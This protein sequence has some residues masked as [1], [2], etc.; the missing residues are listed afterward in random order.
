MKKYTI[1][2]CGSPVDNYNSRI[3]YY[4]HTEGNSVEEAAQ[5]ENIALSAIWV[6]FNGHCEPVEEYK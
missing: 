4:K 2:Y 1:I 6:V 3:T 5:K